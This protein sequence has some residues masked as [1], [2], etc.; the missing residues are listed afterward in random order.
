MIVYGILVSAVMAGRQ[1]VLSHGGSW[2]LGV[3]TSVQSLPG[4]QSVPWST[5]AEGTVHLRVLPLPVLG[6][7]AYSTSG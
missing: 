2:G 5:G 7:K 6:V 1:T 4:P 3:V